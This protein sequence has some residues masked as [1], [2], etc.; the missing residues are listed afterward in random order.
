[1]STEQNNIYN[2]TK[3]RNEMSSYRSIFK[4]TSLFG[5]VEIWK[6]L[7]TIV[8]TKFVAL[9]LGPSGMGIKG[10]FSS[11]TSFIQ[12]ITALGLSNS[13]IRDVSEAYGSGDMKHVSHTVAVLRKLVWITG[14]LGMLSVMGL[15]PVLSKTTFGDYNYI[16]PFVFLSITLLFAQLT[17]G[18]NVILRG[19][20]RLKY[21]VKA[22]V[23]GS[24]LSLIITVPFYYLWGIKGIVPTMILESVSVFVLAYYFAKKVKIEPTQVTLKEAVREGKGM[25]TLGLVMTYNSMLVLGCSYILRIFITRTGGLTDVGLYNA[26]FGIVNTYVGLVFTAMTTDFYPRLAA[27]NI[28]NEKCRLIV[29]QQIEVAIL[30]LGPM[31][32]LFIIIAP[33]AI[34]ALYSQKFLPIIGYMRW[35]CLGIVFRTLGWAISYQFV[36]KG[37][38][39][40]FAINETIANLLG[41]SFDI[42]GYFLWGIT[43]LGISFFVRKIVYFFMVF[44][45]SHKMY[46]YSLSGNVVKIIVTTMV[47]LIVVFLLLILWDNW[48]IYIPLSV[49][50]I[51]EC[52]YAYKEL[53]KRIGIMQMFSRFKGIK[54]EKK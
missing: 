25:M 15:S 49:I 46:D 24:L 29:N 48:W 26:G 50:V 3:D 23:I 42:G 17:A 2:T 45:I 12:S 5:G 7:I 37:D 13:A 1:M 22:G 34:I 38:K 20:R 10:L 28:D 53:D 54:D 9:I 41:L 30:I 32:L 19:T 36:A 51:I 27:V 44:V 43:G 11:A 8:Q 33:T 4:A 47:F 18:Q 14:M 6:I 39:K 21:L 31:L 52:C 40:V 35:A 16:I